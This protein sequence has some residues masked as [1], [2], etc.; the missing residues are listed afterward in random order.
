[1]VDDYAGNIGLSSTLEAFNADF[2]DKL[3][4]HLL[5][6]GRN[7]DLAVGMYGYDSSVQ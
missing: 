2:V 3:Q 1:M 4:M 6:T 5:F 7:K